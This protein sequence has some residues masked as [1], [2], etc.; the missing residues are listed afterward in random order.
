MQD[1][2]NRP[3]DPTII[4]LRKTHHTSWCT[5]S[6]PKLSGILILHV[7]VSAEPELQDH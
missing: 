5:R 7:L 1:M 2:P 3:Y 6:I 4:K